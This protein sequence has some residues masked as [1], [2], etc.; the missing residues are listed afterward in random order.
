VTP[1][2][3]REEIAVEWEALATTVNE[4]VTLYHD[5]AGREPT[6]QKIPPALVMARRHRPNRG[7]CGRLGGA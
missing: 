3:L 4:L 7:S 1:A 6:G 5:I 2:E